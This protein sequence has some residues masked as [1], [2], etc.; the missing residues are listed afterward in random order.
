MFLF[1]TPQI[2]PSVIISS[3]P[4]PISH[5]LCIFNQPAVRLRSVLHS[6]F[7]VVP[8]NFVNSHHRNHNAESNVHRYPG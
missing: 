7:C 3:A 6:I 8:L 2:F 5:F 1:D 4:P